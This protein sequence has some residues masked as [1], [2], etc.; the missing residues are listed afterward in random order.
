MI[1]APVRIMF[2]CVAALMQKIGVHQDNK[3][4]KLLNFKQS[5]K[6][7]VEWSEK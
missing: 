4:D 6:E 1:T 7:V 2:P 5:I 3:R